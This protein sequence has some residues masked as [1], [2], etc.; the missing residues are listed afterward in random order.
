MEDEIDL[1]DYVKVIL[2]RKVFILS[3]FLA[4]IIVAAIF[5]FLSPKVYKISTVLEIGNFGNE[6]LEA[7][8]QLIEKLKT[9]S[10]KITVM[11]S[12]EITEKDY[13]E[14]ETENPKNT[15]LMVREV[16]SSDPERV[17][18]I[19][20]EVNSLILVDHE[21]KLDLL[22]SMTE[23]DM[24]EIQ[25]GLAL[26][27]TQKIYADQGIA[28]LQATLFSLKQKLNFAEPTKITKPPL[29]SENPIRPRPL[30]N[31]AIAGILG[32]F[33]GTFLAFGREWWEK[34]K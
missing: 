20:E 17:K 4:A 1:M 24:E 6:P 28:S 2:K 8:D 26:L 5:S 30:L 16:E 3:L 18:A 14:V 10:Y 31:M 15:R 21:E 27:E 22:K 11:E 12:L 7:P 9:G 19:L 25:R 13:P 23:K 29:I 34:A 32:L 33:M